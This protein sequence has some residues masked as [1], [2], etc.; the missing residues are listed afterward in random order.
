MSDPVCPLRTTFVVCRRGGMLVLPNSLSRKP[1]YV[2]ITTR[3]A[4]I[5]LLQ[6]I[7][8]LAAAQYNMVLEN[9]FTQSVH[10]FLVLMRCRKTGLP[11]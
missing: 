5:A 1:A 4:A 6:L 11:R 2:F 9:V 7:F 3:H 8:F 10:G